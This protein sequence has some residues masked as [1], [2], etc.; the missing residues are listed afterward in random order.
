M[1]RPR[2]KR[3]ATTKSSP[4][5]PPGSTRARARSR[6]GTS[7]RSRLITSTRRSGATNERGEAESHAEGLA[8]EERDVAGGVRNV[9]RPEHLDAHVV[10][11]DA[12][13]PQREAHLGGEG[14]GR[15]R[16]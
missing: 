3:S 13:R 8:P 1:R 12:G 16:P 11:R 9:P 7:N 5:W 6:S 15:V 4:T 14:P 2:A 10:P